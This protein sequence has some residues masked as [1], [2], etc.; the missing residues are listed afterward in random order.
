MYIFFLHG[1]LSSV[2]LSHLF[3]QHSLRNGVFVHV[4]IGKAY[5]KNV[6]NVI[7]CVKINCFVWSVIS[8]M[9]IHKWTHTKISNHNMIMLVL[10]NI[11][12]YLK[13][14]TSLYSNKHKNCK[15]IKFWTPNRIDAAKFKKNPKFW[16]DIFILLNDII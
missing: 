4:W 8:S 11:L 6:G 9:R 15:P 16:H 12:I 2:G 7:Q 5:P 3:V 14:F 10:M 13:Y 1:T